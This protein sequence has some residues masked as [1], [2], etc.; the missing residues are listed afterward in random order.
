MTR[1]LSEQELRD[2]A[3]QQIARAGSQA[4]FAVAHGL[5]AGLV[6]RWLTGHTPCPPVVARALGFERETRY[7][8]SRRPPVA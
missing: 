4:R 1:P 7:V 2:L 3:R 5:N 8:P 6:S